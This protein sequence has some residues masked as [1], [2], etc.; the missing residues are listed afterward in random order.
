MTDLRT[1]LETHI[2]LGLNAS[3]GFFLSFEDLQEIARALKAADEIERLRKDLSRSFESEL[4]ME[5]E[6]WRLKTEAAD[7]IERLRAALVEIA[8][9]LT[10]E[11]LQQT[12]EG[13]IV[14]LVDLGLLTVG[15]N[16]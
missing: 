6:S 8:R 1:K 3:P 14:V 16:E 11:Q 9:M 7:E 10:L 15:A 2:A 5:K 12:T 4:R 13:T